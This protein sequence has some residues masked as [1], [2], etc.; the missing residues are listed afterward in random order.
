MRQW[1]VYL[2]SVH[3]ACCFCLPSTMPKNGSSDGDQALVLMLEPLCHQ[4]LLSHQ[5][6]MWWDLMCSNDLSGSHSVLRSQPSSQGFPPA[7]LLLCTRLQGGAITLSSP[8]VT[9]LQGGR[10]SQVHVL[11][12]VWGK[13]AVCTQR[14]VSEYSH[15]L[16]KDTATVSTCVSPFEPFV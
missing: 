13:D 3:W 9:Q 16:E 1:L 15:L 4:M 7:P 2:S 14:Q 10:L 5:G 8:P 11:L 12:R 6:S